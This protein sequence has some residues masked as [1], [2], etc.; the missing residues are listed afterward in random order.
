MVCEKLPFMTLHKKISFKK[1]CCSDFDHTFSIDSFFIDPVTSDIH[2]ICRMIFNACLTILWTLDIIRSSSISLGKV[3]NCPYFTKVSVYILW[4]TYS[5]WPL[6][7]FLRIWSHLLKKSLMENF[8]FSVRWILR[9]LI[10][11]ISDF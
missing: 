5:Y 1:T 2:H 3:K 11:E 8:F 10:F 7:N 4:M 6:N 9:S